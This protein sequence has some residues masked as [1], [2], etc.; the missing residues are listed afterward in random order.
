MAVASPQKPTAK[1]TAPVVADVAG[2]ITQNIG[3][4]NRIMPKYLNAER[5]IQLAISYSR[6]PELRDC[7]PA[8]FVGVFMAAAQ[9]G[10][11][12]D[13]RGEAY[14]VPFWN[15]KVTPNR[16]EAQFIAGYKG[17]IKLATNSGKVR[18]IF[19]H[20]V[21]E[22]DEF[23]YALGADPY[24]V[25]KPKGKRD[26]V[27]HVYAVAKFKDGGEHFEVMTIGEVHEIRDSFS[28]AAKQGPWVDNSREMSLKTV[29]RRLCKFLPAST[30]LARA[31]ALDEANEAQIPQDLGLNM[32]GMDCVMDA[33]YSVD[34]DSDDMERV[35][36]QVRNGGGPSTNGS[37]PTSTAPAKKAD[38]AKPKERPADQPKAADLPAGSLDDEQ[39]TDG[40]ADAE[41]SGGEVQDHQEADRD[42]LY[43]DFRSRILRAATKDEAVN[44]YT[45]A[46]QDSTLS[47]DHLAKLQTNLRE[48]VNKVKG[49]AARR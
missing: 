35:K 29:C 5:M 26:K 21:Y 10:L 3:V 23:D 19:A 1:P 4:I 6:K 42:I 39:V 16:K 11:E 34:A 14:A 17:L 37:R 30:D 31:V 36:E 40:A 13:I 20:E 43:L 48:A 49:G 25:H 27:T 47:A 15:K 45:E 7:T 9:L 12:L 46:V 38:E 24:L 33:D 28:K 41:G 8:S 2:L 18:N 44:V 22:G 32:L